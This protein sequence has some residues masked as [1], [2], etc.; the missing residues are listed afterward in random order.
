MEI[1]YFLCSVIIGKSKTGDHASPV[2]E[3]FLRAV[4]DLELCETFPWGRLAFDENMNDILKLMN[5]CGGVVG[6]QKVFPN[7]VIPLELL[8]F[9]AIPV[10]QNN[11]RE[12][13]RDAHA[14]CPRM[15]K[16]KFKACHHKGFPMS[17]LYDKLDTTKDIQSIM[18]PSPDEKVLLEEIMN[19]D[20]GGWNDDD[21][22]VVDGWTKLLV[23]KKKTIFF[24]KLYNDDVASREKEGNEDVADNVVREIVGSG[25]VA[26]KRKK[27]SNDG[28]VE[29]ENRLMAVFENGF[30]EIHKKIDAQ[31]KR[32]QV[33]ELNLKWI[34]ENVE[35]VEE[36]VVEVGD[37]E[38]SKEK[39]TGEGNEVAEGNDVGVG[40]VG[41][42]SNKMMRNRKKKRGRQEDGVVRSP[43]VTRQRK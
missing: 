23:E 4:G 18:I 5:D 17:Y 20:E 14:E 11:F 3:F 26:R 21:D 19:G 27:V 8:A 15:C 33:V 31:D 7:F 36:D 9:E 13:V 35:F 40:E 37:D 39:D 16:M 38:S 24:E 41:E 2:E 34:R 30:K 43:I 29:L 6:P 32:L 22:V 12:D 28:L 1:L 25:R 42:P 10:L